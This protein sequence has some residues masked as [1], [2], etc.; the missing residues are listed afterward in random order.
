MVK[1]VQRK[2][3]TLPRVERLFVVVYKVFVKEE[4]CVVLQVTTSH[5][6]SKTS[7]TSIPSNILER[8]KE[9][10]TI[11]NDCRIQ[12]RKG[13]WINNQRISFDD[14]LFGEP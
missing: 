11:I 12:K 10:I 6:K 13:K 9:R 2:H 1:R 14:V 8:R 3:D 5:L 4:R 7:I